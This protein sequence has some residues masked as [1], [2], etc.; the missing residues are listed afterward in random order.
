MLLHFWKMKL[1]VY[2][3]VIIFS[4]LNIQNLMRLH[5]MKYNIV[6][7]H[8]I[9]KNRTS[10][11]I[12]LQSMKRLTDG[13]NVLLSLFLVVLVANTTL[14]SDYSSDIHRHSFDCF[15]NDNHISHNNIVQSKARDQCTLKT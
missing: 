3:G 12:S 1:I 10:C 14:G 4:Q 7:T 13:S 6:Y 9:V 8:I 15:S 2:Y 5:C 11:K